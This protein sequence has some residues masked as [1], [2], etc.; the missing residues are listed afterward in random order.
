CA[1]TDFAFW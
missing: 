1:R